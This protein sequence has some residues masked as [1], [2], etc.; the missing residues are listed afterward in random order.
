VG[1]GGE[2]KSAH[3]D[4]ITSVPG[5][6]MNAASRGGKSSRW[7]E[8]SRRF[9]NQGRGSGVGLRRI[10]DAKGRL[11]GGA[12]IAEA[13]EHHRKLFTEE[14][15]KWSERGEIVEMPAAGCEVRDGGGVH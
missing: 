1:I 8:T 14:S 10:A 7:G 13:L 2:L 15:K 5:M 11:G 12:E 3:L 6:E 9:N 4:V